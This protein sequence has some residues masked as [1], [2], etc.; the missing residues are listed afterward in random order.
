MDER[1]NTINIFLRFLIS[2]PRVIKINLIIRTSTN[3][4]SALAKS[5]VGKNLCS[6]SIILN[7]TSSISSI[8]RMTQRWKGG[9]P[10]FKSNLTS[11]K[12]FI[13]TIL[14]I[15]KTKNTP[16]RKRYFSTL[17]TGINWINNQDSTSIT[18]KEIKIFMEPLANKTTM[19]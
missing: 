16:W 10:I 14:I 1:T 11:K 19:V 5:N 2:T 13:H 6:V 9:I 17:H 3:S 8:S 18:I 15:T 4:F 12:G 7:G